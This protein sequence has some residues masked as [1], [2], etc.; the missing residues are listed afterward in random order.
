MSIER[1]K[2][3]VKGGYNFMQPKFKS[4][5]PSPT[6]DDYVNGYIW[7]Y[8]C[9][10]SNDKNAPIQEINQRTYNKLLSNVYYSAV[11]IKWKISESKNVQSNVQY[12]TLKESNAL[13]I[14]TAYDVIPSLKLYLPNLS[15][16]SK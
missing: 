4:Y 9:Q 13:S 7:R 3:V 11:S 1:Y 10:K 14:K 12:K 5:V 15:Q 6:E 16:F 2:Q 8:F